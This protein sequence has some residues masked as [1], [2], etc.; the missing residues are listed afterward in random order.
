VKD[1]THCNS[2]RHERTPEN[3]GRRSGRNGSG[4]T[5]CRPCKIE[6]RARR[7]WGKVP[8]RSNVRPTTATV[9]DWLLLREQGLTLREA[10]DRMGM[11]PGALEK[12]LERGRQRGLIT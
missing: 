8:P 7:M 2:G 1:R 4:T 11:N 10:A 12:A 6:A 5:F 3:V 9:E